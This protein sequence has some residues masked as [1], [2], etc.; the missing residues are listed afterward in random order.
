[1]YKKI[2]HILLISI[3]LAAII[4]MVI[5][6]N[7]LQNFFYQELYDKGFKLEEI[8]INELYLLAIPDII[9]RL[10]FSNGDSMMKIDLESNKTLLEESFW[11]K[12]AVISK[13]FPNKIHITIYENLPEF[14]WQD[15]NKY[16]ALDA[17]GNILKEINNKELELFKNFII[18]SGTNAKLFTQN[19]LVFIKK[20][21]DIYQHI[22]KIERIGDR[23]WNIIFI[24]NMTIKLPELNPELAWDNFIILN[25]KIDFFENPVKAIDFRIKDKLFIEFDMGNNISNL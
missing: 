22:A 11:I 21:I 2:F 5:Y 12:K 7:I 20:N 1:M 13:E 23:R 24:N 15:D 8:I 25:D 9:D 17:M 6:R 19:L 4:L 18:L 16:F 14:I 10:N 3:I